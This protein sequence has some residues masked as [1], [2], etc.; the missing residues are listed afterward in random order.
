MTASVRR[1]RLAWTALVIGAGALLVA[2]MAGS[3]LL[4]RLLSGVIVARLGGETAARGVE[5]KVDARPP[6]R[7]LQGEVDTL[8]VDLREARFGLL[9]VDS[10]LLDAYDLKLDASRLW[11]T[12][13]LRV[14]R[15]GRLTATLRLTEDDLNRYLWAT[16]DRDRTFH[17]T[18]GQGYAQAEGSLTLL[19][20]PVPLRL[21]GRFVIDEPASLRFAP[22]EFFL[23]KMPV[24][25][26]F[27]EN[28]V[29]KVFYVRIRLEELPVKV[30][31]TDVRL[32]KGRAFLFA[33]NQE[34]V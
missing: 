30:R 10:F 31:L 3:A 12:G 25:R 19:G 6:W 14:L 2:L 21:K 13:T 24:P 15:Q 1:R 28:V 5:V 26:P 18:L 9:P 16:V 29:A 11:R 7:L 20:Q 17:L 34:R 8:H 23:A 4:P 27:L 33:T 22:D 32:E